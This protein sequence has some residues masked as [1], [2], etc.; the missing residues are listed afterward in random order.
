MQNGTLQIHSRISDDEKLTFRLWLQRQFTER[1]KRNARYSLRA[2]ARFLEIDPSSLS[3][4]LSGKRSLS[5]DKMRAL[6]TKTSSATLQD[7]KAFGLL[8]SESDENYSQVHL[9]NFTAI[10]DWYHYAIVELTCITSFNAKPNWIARKLSI[11]VEEAKAAVQ[12][13]KRVGLLKEENGR[14]VKSAD[15]FTNKSG[16]ATSSAHREL[17]RQ[18]IEKALLA[19]DEC[20]PKEK[21]ITS[22]TMAI[23]EANLDRARDLIKKFRRDL[24]ELLENGEQTRIYNLAVQL[25]P[26]STNK[27]II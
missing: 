4:I 2:F 18:V 19:V 7:L 9:D 26:I 22:M 24:C 13:L 23:D 6:C 17:Q 8:K 27:E 14:L 1:C 11:T 25:Y 16:V 10:S 3:Q 21:D 12:R 20:L 15:H 5:R